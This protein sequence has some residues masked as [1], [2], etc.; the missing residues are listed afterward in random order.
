MLLMEND[1]VK[2]SVLIRSVILS[3]LI[4]ASVANADQPLTLTLLQDEPMDLPK[5]NRAY[6]TAAR[7]FSVQLDLL[8]GFENTDDTLV[9]LVRPNGEKS[10]FEPGEDMLVTVDNAEPGPHVLVASSRVAH[11]TMF[12]NLQPQRDELAP[13]DQ[14]EEGFEEEES[15]EPLRMPLMATR[16]KYMKPI[17]ARLKEIDTD[18]PLDVERPATAGKRYDYRVKLTA[19]GT[20]HGRVFTPMNQSIVSVEGTR[21]DVY[22]EGKPV[23][24]AVCDKNGRWSIKNMSSGV[25][26]IVAT[27]RAGYTAF[28]FEIIDQA[29]LAMTNDRGERFTSRMQP[30]VIQG[31]IPSELAVVLIPL[32]MVDDVIEIIEVYYYE[33]DF[34]APLGPTDDFVVAPLGPTAVPSVAPG[35]GGVSAAGASGVGILGPAVIAA[36]IA[37]ADSSDSTQFSVLNASGFGPAQ[38]AMTSP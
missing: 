25:Y 19:N 4:F 8:A 7:E 27:G 36:V 30:P 20:L 29:E 34:P 33:D 2:R 18:V 26:G 35:A 1:I 6:F 21:V 14:M 12:V 10:Q 3:G 24:F 5:D 15:D 9:T 32:P 11:G 23:G 31:E 16:A 37:A 13:P 38:G 17:L 28:A 22:L